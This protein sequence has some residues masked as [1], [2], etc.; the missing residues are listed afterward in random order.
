MPND[1]DSSH[2]VVLGDAWITGKVKTRFLSSDNLAALDISVETDDGVVRLAGN[3]ATAAEK[4]LA[5]E[6][7]RN[8]RGV[9]DVHA[10][11]LKV[12]G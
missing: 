7:A 2:T 10:A 5:V 6:T 4:A 9:L 8:V 12:A 11:S 1:F 3:V